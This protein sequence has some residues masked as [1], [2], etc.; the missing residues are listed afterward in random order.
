MASRYSAAGTIRI[1]GR[2]C[3]STELLERRVYEKDDRLQHELHVGCQRPMWG[4]GVINGRHYGL[5]SRCWHRWMMFDRTYY[6][7]QPNPA[8]KLFDP[9]QAAQREAL[10]IGVAHERIVSADDLEAMWGD[11]P[12]PEW[13]DEEDYT[14]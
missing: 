4:D 7:L 13:I 9:K 1:I 12:V 11:D 10:F 2:V 5:C 6:L 14:C 3:M 8:S